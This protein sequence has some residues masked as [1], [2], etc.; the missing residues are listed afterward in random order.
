MASITLRSVKGSPLTNNEIDANFSNINTEVGTKLT[1]SEYTA[2]DVLEKLLTVDGNGSGLDA[3]TVDGYNPSTTNTSNTIVLRDASG[4]F[5]AGNI[6][7]NLTGN[8]SGNISGNA[9]TVTNGVYTNQS[10]NNPS[11]ITG[12]AGSKVTSIPNSSLTNSAITINGVSVSLGGSISISG[13]SNTWT[14]QQTFRDS[15]FSITDE[16]DTTKVLNF[17]LSGISTGNTRVL[18]APDETGTIATQSY[19]QNYVQT[20]GRNSQ[21][22]KSVES[23]SL[24]IPLNSRGVD[25]DII[26]QY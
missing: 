8:V 23:V 22:S 14:A 4:N 6:S 19:T 17:Q 24:G 9:A 7:A 16:T 13:S 1:A 5:S 25:G 18:F 2:S 15:L 26:Y 12:L 10:Y 3:D 20:A 21:G 11:W